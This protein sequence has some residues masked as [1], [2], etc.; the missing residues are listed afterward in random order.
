MAN[1]YKGFST[2]DRIR[3][4]YT[5][6][7]AE[8][9]KRDLLNELKTRKGERVMRPNFGTTIE[10]LLMNPLDDYVEQEIREEVLRVVSKDPRVEVQSLFSQVLDHTIRLELSLILKPFLDEQTLYVEYSQENLEV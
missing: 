10:N 6:T 5:V 3:P 9:V 1:I 8:A 7:N 4:P 2:V